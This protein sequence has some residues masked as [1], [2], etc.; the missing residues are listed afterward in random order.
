M[1]NGI[2][3]FG[4]YEGTAEQSETL[5]AS[6][7]WFPINKATTEGRE[8]AEDLVS[9][10]FAYAGVQRDIT[11]FN[12]CAELDELLGLDEYDKGEAE[13]VASVSNRHSGRIK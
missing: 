10:G 12:D 2:T 3:S 8:T 1:D 7:R 5:I 11:Y 4:A 6:E 9:S 13:A